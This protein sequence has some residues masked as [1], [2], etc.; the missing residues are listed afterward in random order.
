MEKWDTAIDSQAKAF[1]VSVREAASL[2]QN[3]GRILA[4]TYSPGGPL[5]QLAA[6]GGQGAA[7]AALDVLIR[8]VAVALAPRRITVNSVSPGWIEGT[9]LN[10]L[11]EPVQTAIREWHQSGWTPMGQIGTPADV[12]N[13]VAML[14][15][16]DVG[17]I[18]GQTLEVGGGASLM[19]AHLPSSTSRRRGRRSAHRHN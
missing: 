14:C 1:L 19:D 11:P 12:G 5:R 6:L 17:W 13:A 9:V 16:P 3:G 8:Y 4:I 18:T 10:S 15:S 2:M 7:K